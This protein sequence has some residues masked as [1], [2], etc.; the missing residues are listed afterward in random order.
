M[1]TD[2]TT[3]VSWLD[4][5]RPMPVTWGVPWPRGAVP[6]LL[7]GFAVREEHADGPSIPAQ[8]WIT[9]TWP[10]GSVKWSAHSLAAPASPA[11]N[12][13]VV[14]GQP[15]AVSDNPVILSEAED[16]LTVDTGT[17][18]WVIPRRGSILVRSATRAGIE[19]VRD[20]R[21]VSLWQ[22]R[23]TP[24]DGAGTITRQRWRGE[25]TGVVAEQTGPIRAVLR[26]E[27]HHEPVESGE[28]GQRLPFTLRLYFSAGSD[29]LRIVHTLVW[30]GD[31][32][33]DFLA[34]LGV[35]ADVPLGSEPHNRHVR[36]AGPTAGALAG[37]G[38]P[39]GASGDPHRPGFL[40]EAVRGVTGL[41][42]DPGER[43]RDAQVAGHDCGPVEDWAETVS[44]RVHLIPVWNDWTLDQTSAD[45]FTLRKRTGP[46]F[47]WVTIPSGT[48]S[49]GYGYVGDLGGG[50]GFGLR[51]FWRMHPTRLDIRGAATDTATAT[52]WLWSPSAP[53]MDL[54][55]Y[56]DG[57]GQDSYAEQ[58]EGLEITYE[59]YEPGFGEP[60]GIART[61]ELVLHAYPATPSAEAL[62]ADR[63]GSQRSRPAG[64]L[65][66]APPGGRGLR[67]LGA[68]RP[69]DP[70]QGRDRG[71]AGGALRLLCRPTSSSGAGTV[72]GTTA[73]SCTPTTPTG[74]T[75]RYDVGGY[76]WDNS[77]L[78]P[79]LWLWYPVP[80]HRSRRRLPLRRGDD[81]A[82]RR[83][84]RLPPRPVEGPG[85]AGTTS[86]TGGA[87]PSS[88]GSPVACTG[89]STTS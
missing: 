85:H 81:P 11:A 12:Y 21:L 89:G 48:R 65:S 15:P 76:A 66:G 50:L 64:G 60:R 70:G 87:A 6:A 19:T 2:H 73:T 36:L 56:H 30:D 24:D 34:G 39:S 9:A 74:T 23:P 25:I 52:I 26:V 35:R 41:R 1:T 45:G 86:R 18:R 38:N 51:D 67:R 43:F 40:T 42:R 84:R 71:P 82:H 31:A 27:G 54:R 5:P 57:L 44:R 17:V 80:A 78:S 22:D 7:D 55:F 33:C 4:Q 20:V 13:A 37:V 72:S 88:C 8:S 75:W 62:A 58:L 69:V 49:A 63:C 83:G 14:P 28:R 32:E 46:G 10:D 61:H 59:D 29:Q 53:A 47:S 79:D 16:A 3:L 77:E 68:C